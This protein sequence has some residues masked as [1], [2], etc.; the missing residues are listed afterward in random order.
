MFKDDGRDSNCVSLLPT[1]CATTKG[2]L[3][4]DGSHP[5]YFFTIGLLFGT[6]EASECS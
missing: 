6:H 3:P 5:Q 4:A 1:N 2:F